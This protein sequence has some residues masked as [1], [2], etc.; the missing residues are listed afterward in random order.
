MVYQEAGVTQRGRGRPRGTSHAAILDV[1]RRLFAEHGYAETS[2]AHIAEAAGISRTTLF[3]YFP[4]KS[5]LIWTEFDENVA[6]L[7][8]EFV[9]SEGPLVDRLAAAI[10][11]AARYPADDHEGLRLRWR[12][13]REDAELRASIG[14]R[15]ESMI[16]T[17]ID[18]AMRREPHADRE[19]VGY[20]VRALV[21]VSGGSTEAWAMQRHTDESLDQFVAARLHRFVEALRPLLP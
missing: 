7:E 21:A 20:V 6:R 1:A 12:L 13:A 3:S 19:Q 14:E 16:Q 5:D 2:L 17:L 15:L 4:A 10:V 8:P 9:A 18:T 11:S